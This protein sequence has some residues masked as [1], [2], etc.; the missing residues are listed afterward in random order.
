MPK[1]IALY[2]VEHVYD[3]TTMWRSVSH[4]RSDGA[5]LV[6]TRLVWEPSGPW[7]HRWPSECDSE[8]HTASGSALNHLQCGSSSH[9]VLTAV[10]CAILIVPQHR[11]D[12]CLHSTP[13]DIVEY[14]ILSM[15]F[16][17][18]IFIVKAQRLILQDKYWIV[19]FR[20]IIWSWQLWSLTS[21]LFMVCIYFLEIPSR[22]IFY[23]PEWDRTWDPLHQRPMS[24]TLDQTNPFLKLLKWFKMTL[25]Q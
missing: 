9:T 22:L 24:W 15:Y 21:I 25:W 19:V 18:N 8:E 5:V 2:Q 17:F 4:G 14:Y 10:S 13:L 3:V 16:K 7:S 23:V 11:S 1:I 6:E 12:L 20:W